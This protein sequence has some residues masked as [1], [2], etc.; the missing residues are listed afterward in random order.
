MQDIGPSK[1][2]V[3]GRILPGAP[4]RHILCIRLCPH[5]AAT[6]GRQTAT[7]RSVPTE[8]LLA[9]SSPLLDGQYCGISSPSIRFRSAASNGIVVTD[10][11]MHLGVEKIR[12]ALHLS[13]AECAAALGVPLETFR[14]WDAGRRALPPALLLRARRSIRTLNTDEGVRLLLSHW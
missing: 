14:V 10:G 3:A 4:P 13:Q 12:T 8:I 6:D 7:G 9:I 11:Y 1:P 2:G 5:K